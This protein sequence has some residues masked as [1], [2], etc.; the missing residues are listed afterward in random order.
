MRVYNYLII[1]LGVMIVMNLMGVDTV[2]SQIVDKFNIDTI[3]D[4]TLSDFFDLGWAETLSFA[5]VGISIGLLISGKPELAILFSFGS[6]LLL[7]VADFVSLLTYTNSECG[8]GSEC[9]W[10]YYVLFIVL[11]PLLG[12]YIQSIVSWMTGRN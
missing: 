9:R 1:M 5:A 2:S 10:L 12:G 6:M 8:V 11:I 7:F 3:S 4:F